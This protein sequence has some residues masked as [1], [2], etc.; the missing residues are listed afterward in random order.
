MSKCKINVGCGPRNFG[1]DWIHIDGGDYPHLN[2]KDIMLP[3]FDHDSVDVIYAS[4]VIEYFD[5]ILVQGLISI[6][7][8]KLKEGGLLYLAVPDFRKL[9]SLYVEDKCILYEI[10][11]PLYGRMQMDEAWIYHKTV[12]D[13]DTLYGLMYSC[14]FTGIQEWAILKDGYDDYSQ[15]MKK[16]VR[17]SLN[18]RGTK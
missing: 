1:K 6:W 7:R 8:D 15:A 12:Y 10:I 18:L 9:A 5:R 16:G 4:H 2:G 11:G 14:G 17:I 3:H 13:Y